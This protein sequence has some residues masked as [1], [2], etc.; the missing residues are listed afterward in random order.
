MYGFIHTACANLLE[1]P[2]DVFIIPT[3]SSLQKTFSSFQKCSVSTPDESKNFRQIR[4][5]GHRSQSRFSTLQHWQ[6][7]RLPNSKLNIAFIGSGN[8]A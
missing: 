5:G 8:I 4:S 6:G 3:G 7:R 1:F 2:V